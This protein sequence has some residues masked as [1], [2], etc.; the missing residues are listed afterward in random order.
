MVDSRNGNG[1]NTRQLF[2]YHHR[3]RISVDMR[4]VL[5]LKDADRAK[6]MPR[7]SY[8]VSFEVV[9]FWREQILMVSKKEYLTFV[10]K[11]T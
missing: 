9:T 3:Y 8:F 6:L 5:L 11:D 4:R 1:G 10:E 7:T 2:Q